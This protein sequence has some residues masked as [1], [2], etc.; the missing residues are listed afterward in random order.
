VDRALG[1]PPAGAQLKLVG[2]A[3]VD[4]IAVRRLG[5]LAPFAAFAASSQLHLPALASEPG[6]VESVW[7]LDRGGDV[8]DRAL[9]ALRDTAGRRDIEPRHLAKRLL[10]VHGFRQVGVRR[11]R[12]SGSPRESRQHEAGAKPREMSNSSHAHR[13]TRYAAWIRFRASDACVR[14]LSGS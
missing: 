1:P 8:S 2:A 13:N 10:E 6:E 9:V 5:P 4:G 14:R 3:E 7:R 11:K 12:W